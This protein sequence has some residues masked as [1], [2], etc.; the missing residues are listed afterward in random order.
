LQHRLHRGA[1]RNLL[2][3]GLHPQR[4][5]VMGSPLREVI[6]HY[7]DAIAASGVL[8]ALA[9]APSQYIAASL[10]RQESVDDAGRLAGLLQALRE[11]TH[12]TRLIGK[13][14]DIL[15]FAEPTH[16]P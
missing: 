13:I 11:Y 15:Q 4:T 12:S 9:L 7:K 2:R 3:E 16:L 6:D 5:L 8:A 1:R 10:H 14:E